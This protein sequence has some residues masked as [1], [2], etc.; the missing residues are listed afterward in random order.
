MYI[1]F[2]Q[3]NYCISENKKMSQTT[4]TT[5]R[6]L[7]IS[8]RSIPTWLD[9]Q[10]QGYTF[11]LKTNLILRSHLEATDLRNTHC[12]GADGCWESV[13][14]SRYRPWKHPRKPRQKRWGMNDLATHP[15]VVFLNMPWN[16]KKHD[17]DIMS[18]LGVLVQE[19]NTKQH[20]KGRYFHTFANDWT[21]SNPIP[22]WKLPNLT[23][24]SQ[25]TSPILQ[26]SK[27]PNHRGCRFVARLAPR[28]VM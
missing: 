6:Y 23:S 2:L 17:I 18:Q 26:P 28:P 7:Q 8:G 11:F 3:A 24:P 21:D 20:K 4:S 9:N 5:T 22:S 25:T 10:M 14:R 12:F 1:I 27:G 15:A 19:D 13:E 16:S